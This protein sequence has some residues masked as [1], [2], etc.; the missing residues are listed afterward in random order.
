MMIARA[1]AARLRSYPVRAQ[2]IWETLPDVKTSISQ[3]RGAGHFSQ[4]AQL[5]DELW[6]DDR[7][8][9]VLSTRTDAL[10]SAP[11]KLSAANDSKAAQRALEALGV[12]DDDPDGRWDDIF[13]DW[14]LGDVSSNG[15]LLNLGLAKIEWYPED[16]LVWPRVTPMSAQF[17]RWDT[18]TR[19]YWFR[20]ENQGEL[21]LPRLD[22]DARGN[23]D[24][25][26][27][28]PFGYDIWRRAM[29]CWMGPL[30]IYRRWDYVDWA[31]YNEVYGKPTKVGYV[32]EGKKDEGEVEAFLAELAAAGANATVKVPRP[33]TAADGGGAGVGWGVE[34]VEAKSRGWDTFQG[35]K[36]DVD[37]DIAVGY[38]GVNLLTDAA[39][40]SLALS[41][42]Q[43]P[44]FLNRVAK[45]AKIAK[46]LR[47][48]VLWHWAQ[49]N[50]G[51]G[52]LA[53]RVV[54]EVRPPESE[55]EEG[56]G[57]KA[58]GEGA[59]ALEDA[60]AKA[61]A[62]GLVNV[63]AI[64]EAHGVP[65]NSEEEVAAAKEEAAARAAAIAQR[66]A[67]GSGG[68]ASGDE[69][70]DPAP[71]DDDAEGEDREGVLPAKKKTAALQ[72]RY[73]PIPPVRRYEFQGLPIAVE[74]PA[75]STRVWRE[76][77]PDGEVIGQTNMRHDYGYVEGVMGSDKEELDVYIGPD[78]SAAQVYVV[79]QL[80]S[81]DYKAHDEDKVML[82]FPSEAEA[83]AAYAAHRNDGEK[84]IDGVSVIPLNRFKAKLQRR[85]GATRKITADA[86][87][88][89]GH[90]EIERRAVR[91]LDRAEHMKLAAA[92]P[93]AKRRAKLYGDQVADEAVKLSRSVVAADLQLVLEAIK[94]A[95]NPDDLRSELRKAFP[96]MDPGPMTELVY[97]ARMMARVGGKAAA[98]KRIGST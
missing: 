27:W 47:M 66:L 15:N 20:S 59:L 45:D 13:P 14:M 86:K 16:G 22:D 18:L 77:G 88:P 97:R 6:T 73:I 10:I 3:L 90:A 9:G 1:Q 44:I 37:K 33:A 5:A 28:T 50:F 7:F 65:T 54:F 42:E 96:D 82:G 89:H 21:E 31:N 71:G 11:V 2:S 8:A 41:Q 26:M 83:R 74:N 92:T 93:A 51:D 46:A 4:A 70:A 91:M 30:L 87:A 38:L 72:A 63:R 61:G 24:W 75:G 12:T 62:P 78:E 94:R 40:G 25:L 85:G 17:V 56:A 29:I 48:Q 81:P 34:L 23:G 79:H 64:F 58:L 69:H 32:P 39:G 84:A 98:V 35:F 95:K 36:Q 53:P 55:A 43:T 76:D 60:A 57:Y 19:S 80:R 49:R 68:P 52:S 67:P